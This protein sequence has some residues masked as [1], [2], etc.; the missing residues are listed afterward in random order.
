MG[1]IL[2]PSRFRTFKTP[3][4]EV[5]G[6]VTRSRSARTAL[7]ADQARPLQR[8]SRGCRQCL[9]RWALANRVLDDDVRFEEWFCFPA[10]TTTELSSLNAPKLR[11]GTPPKPSKKDYLTSKGFHE[12]EGAGS[13]PT[14]G[15]SIWDTITPGNVI[16]RPD[17]SMQA[18]D[19]QIGPAKAEGLARA[20]ACQPSH[21]HRKAYRLQQGAI[22]LVRCNANCAEKSR[23]IS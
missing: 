18:V 8:P 19:L 21:G 1:K 13:T 7:Q 5:S 10:K 14:L 6:V 22:F 11:S 3:S 16:V 4:Q 9:Q 15:I 17:G 20:I 23:S 12:E 2:D